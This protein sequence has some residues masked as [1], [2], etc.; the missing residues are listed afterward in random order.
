MV[1]SKARTGIRQALK[2]Q[3]ESQSIAFG[4][5]LLNRSLASA[6]KSINDLDFRRLRRVFK[7]FGVRRLDEVLAAIGNGKLMSY[8][9][10]QRLLAEDDPDFEGVPVESGGPVAVRGGEGLVVNYGRCCGP[11]P[12]DAIVGHMTP[13]KGF[14][15]HVETCPNM[16]EIRRRRGAKEIIPA[17]WAATKDN[18]FLTTLRLQVS[19]HK[20]IIAE[21]ASTIAEVDAGVENIHVEE[22]SAD[23]TSVVA[24]V[25]V[26]VGLTV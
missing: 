21:L 17:H 24:R 1:S 9:V 11:V 23:V 4:R 20:G 7:E 6:N 3:Q 25:G 8:A 10:A 22:R 26:Q 2:T 14:V 13:G 18:E 15:V 19:R 12:G 16:V 5:Q